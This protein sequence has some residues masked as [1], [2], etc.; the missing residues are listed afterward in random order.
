MLLKTS[1][2]KINNNLAPHSLARN[3]TPV[4]EIHHYETRGFHINLSYGPKTQ[5]RV[6][7]EE[8]RLYYSGVVAWNALPEEAKEAKDVN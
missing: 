7:Q 6:S 8:P 4:R 1:I 3:F 5:H 2:N